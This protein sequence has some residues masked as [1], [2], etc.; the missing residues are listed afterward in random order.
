MRATAEAINAMKEQVLSDLLVVRTGMVADRTLSPAEGEALASVET[1]V[2]IALRV[3]S[4]V[5]A[6][7]IKDAMQVVEIQARM[8]GKEVFE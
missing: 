2:A 4:T 1:F 5:N 3:M 6:S 7:K 8:D